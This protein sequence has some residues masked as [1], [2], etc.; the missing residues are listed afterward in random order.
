[1]TFPFM[2]FPTKRAPC[3]HYGIEV[4]EFNLSYSTLIVYILS[5][6]MSAWEHAIA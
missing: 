6:M 2:Y 3:L 4:V 1:M 5:A